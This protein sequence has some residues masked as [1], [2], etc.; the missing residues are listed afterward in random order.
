MKTCLLLL[1]ISLSFS[2]TVLAQED[3][4]AFGSLQKLFVNKQTLFQFTA[5]VNISGKVESI[6]QYVAAQ[7]DDDSRTKLSLEYSRIGGHFVTVVEHN[8]SVFFL[9]RSGA[10]VFE[11]YQT[12]L[13]VKNLTETNF[14]TSSSNTLVLFDPRSMGLC[15]YDELMSGTSFEA[16][17]MK[18]L[19]DRELK[20]RKTG[21][22]IFELVSK[23]GVLELD[24]DIDFNPVRSN[25]VDE[26]GNKLAWSVDYIK[27]KGMWLP[28]HARLVN[29]D[30]NSKQCKIGI[31][32]DW[33][34]QNGFIDSGDRAIERLSKRY[35]LKPQ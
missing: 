19:A 31:E 33:K 35:D 18:W 25:L 23:F 32:V 3:T 7:Q 1:M 21:K 6:A 14:G 28:S 17:R 10:K 5:D 13:T 11:G 2:G 4:E 26:S 16:I 34:M 27:H 20:V 29:V 12:D 15:T 24:S 22:T 8:G 9:G 30:R